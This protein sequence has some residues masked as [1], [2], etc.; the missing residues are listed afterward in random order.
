MV[1][2]I[3][4]G[5]REFNNYKLL[6]ENCN[7]ILFE[8]LELEIEDITIISG[9]AKGADELGEYYAKEYGIKIKIYKAEWDKYKRVAGMLRNEEMAKNAD[10]VILFDLG[11]KGTKNMLEQAIKYKLPY[12][13]FKLYE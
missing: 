10:Y 13:H 4:A 7:R 8:E 1:R 6:E 9:K 3:I 2:V 5:S 12:R 11:T